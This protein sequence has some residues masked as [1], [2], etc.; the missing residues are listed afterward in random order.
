MSPTQTA[1]YTWHQTLPRLATREESAALRRL[2]ED[3]GYTDKGIT[4]RLNV[5]DLESYSSASTEPRPMER[6]LDALI[7]L[8]YDCTLVEEEA[9]TSLLSAADLALLES[10]ELVVRHPVRQRMVYA[11]A[12]IL[13]A[14][15]FL[16][17]CDRGAHAPDGTTSELPPDVVYP[18]ILDTTRR[19]LQS[20]PDTPCDAMLDIGTGTGIAALMAARSANHVWASDLTARAA[21]YAEI[22]RRLANLDNITVV[23]GDLYEPVE[24]LTFDR[25][26]IHPPY[27]PAKK[28]KFLYRDAGEDGEQI[29]R[30]AVEGLP[31]MLRPGGRFYSVQMAGDREGESLE[32]R[33]RKW[34]GPLQGEFDVVV[35]AHSIRPPADFLADRMVRANATDLEDRDLLELWAETKTKYLVYGTLLIERHSTPRPALT[36]RTLS[37]KGYTGRHL[38]WLLDWQKKVAG[39]DSTEML[40]NARPSLTPDCSLHSVSR[41]RDGRFQMEEFVL[42]SQRPFHSTFRSEGWV[43]QVLSECD[44]MRTWREHFDRA[45][46]AG[47]I[48]ERIPAKEFAGL[49]SLLVSLG[50]LRVSEHPL[51]AA[52]G[53]DEEIE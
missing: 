27:V 45:K 26:T 37:G 44:G 43:T 31:D 47:L 30:R 3:S 19:F 4:Q 50:I 9:V 46:G 51:P 39:A 8:F 36:A 29:I 17:V 12:A 20:L 11:S 2:F 23:E 24:G 52:D 6:P 35:G 10:L 13:P 41:M 21:R 40:L 32:Q 5:D 38:D 16:T 28:S 33:V 25:I 15:G 34:L 22:N 53:P 48:S 1:S 42:K 49:L 7:R 14:Y 18:A